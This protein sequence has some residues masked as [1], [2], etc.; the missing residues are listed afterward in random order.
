M[1]IAP[2]PSEVSVAAGSHTIMHNRTPMNVPHT[3]VPSLTRCLY[4]AV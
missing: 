1:S 3:D 2:I 4:G